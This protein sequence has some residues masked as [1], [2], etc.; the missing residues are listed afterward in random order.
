MGFGRKLL[1]GRSETV[2][3]A[4]GDALRQAAGET[5]AQRTARQ[6]RQFGNGQVFGN[7]NWTAPLWAT[8]TTGDEITISFGLGKNEG[9]VLVANGHITTSS[10]FYTNAKKEK[11]HDH[12][13]AD[14][15]VASR[16]DRHK[17]R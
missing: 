15:T 8:R 5:K 16:V 11:E 7:N 13:L 10:Q 12:L 14:G 9:Q 6:E 3:G 4:L 1:F 2:G 17:S